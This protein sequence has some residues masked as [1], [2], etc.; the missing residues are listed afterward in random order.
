MVDVPKRCDVCDGCGRIEYIC[1]MCEGAGRVHYQE[2]Y[3]DYEYEETCGSCGGNGRGSVNCE[4][5]FGTGIYHTDEERNARL[6]KVR[7]QHDRIKWTERI[8]FVVTL[9]AALVMAQIIHEY[10]ALHRDWFGRFLRITAWFA[11]A[12][13]IEGVVLARIAKEGIGLGH[14]STYGIFNV[15][16]FWGVAIVVYLYFAFH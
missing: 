8:Y 7:E 13:F 1:S 15:I 11:G 12:G 14:G 4:F 16:I 6:A 10:A 5:C 2:T 9:I 3:Y